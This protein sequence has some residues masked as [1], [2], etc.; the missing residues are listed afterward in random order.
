MDAASAEAAA[1]RY[2]RSYIDCCSGSGA[3][4]SVSVERC[5]HSGLPCIQAYAP[6]AECRAVGAPQCAGA[7]FPEARVFGAHPRTFGCEDCPS[8]CSAMEFA[9]PTDSWEGSRYRRHQCWVSTA[10]LYSA[11][12]PWARLTNPQIIQGSDS[13]S[14]RGGIGAVVCAFLGLCTCACGFAFLLNSYDHT[15]NSQSE[16][17]RCFL[18]IRLVQRF[19]FRSLSLSEGE[20]LDSCTCVCWVDVLGCVCSGVRLCDGAG[21]H[22]DDCVGLRGQGQHR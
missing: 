22:L 3:S 4:G 16:S 7:E 6:P 20:S 1:E 18:A 14:T 11:G 8:C 2:R 13:P 10:T 21:P 17:C 12:K 15:P 5:L 9:S 19:R